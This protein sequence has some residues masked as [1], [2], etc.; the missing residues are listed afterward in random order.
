MIRSLT[1]LMSV[2]LMT[3]GCAG[4]RMIVPSSIGNHPDIPEQT[5]RELAT[6]IEE[7][8][9]N[10]NREHGISDYEGILV[11]DES[12]QQAIRTRA[13]R[14]EILDVFMDTGFAWE[15]ADGMVHILRSKAYKQ[16]GTSK[17]RNRDAL[18]I[19]SE[20]N[21][22]WTLYEGIIDENRYPRRSLDELRAIFADVRIATLNSGQQYENSDGELAVR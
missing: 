9:A 3:G 13:A 22:R 16:T 17:S 5:M 14:R 4:P 20:N 8:V 12:V 19:M 10:K 18:L 7:A 6:R 2:I 15:R 21:D 11:S 1:V